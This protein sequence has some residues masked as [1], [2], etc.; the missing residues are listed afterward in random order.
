VTIEQTKIGDKVVLRVAGRMDAENTP[1]FRGKCESC[2]S[3][4]AT[5]L[6]IDLGDLAYVSSMGLG[7]FVSIA[8]VL[9]DKG[10]DLRICRLSGLVKQVFEITCLNRVFPLHESVES[11]LLGN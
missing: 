8:K 10:G 3:E 11:A 6:V 9:R 2:I 1:V 7:C 4:G 5:S